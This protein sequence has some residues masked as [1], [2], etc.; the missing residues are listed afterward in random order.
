MRQNLLVSL[1][2]LG[3]G[4]VFRSIRGCRFAIRAVLRMRV[5]N[6]HAP[7]LCVVYFK[8]YALLGDR[9]R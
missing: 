7:P 9:T 8:Q 4:V 6:C 5:V 3:R 1:A 2:D